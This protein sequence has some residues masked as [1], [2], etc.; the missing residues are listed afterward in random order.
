MGWTKPRRKERRHPLRTIEICD[1]LTCGGCL[2]CLL[3]QA[4]GQLETAHRTIEASKHIVRAA[5]DFAQNVQNELVDG[6]AE[7]P[8]AADRSFRE[9]V[10]A[11]NHERRCETCG[12]GCDLSDSEMILGSIACRDCRHIYSQPRFKGAYRAG[13]RSIESS[14]LPTLEAADAF[15]AQAP[16]NA[17]VKRILKEHDRTINDGKF[18]LHLFR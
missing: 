6:G 3:A 10:A 9:L 4:S 1:G 12:V 18:F 17:R 15:L 7:M 5:E 8:L 14:P 11:L 2:E 13:D 16:A